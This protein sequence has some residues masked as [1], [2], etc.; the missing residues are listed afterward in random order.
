MKAP[1]PARFACRYCQYYA[2]EGRRGGSCQRLSVPVQGEWSACSL[3]SPSFSPSWDALEAAAAI[4][5]RPST[6]P[7]ATTSP[8]LHPIPVSSIV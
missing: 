5:P 4:E 1:I 8:H 2:P 7:V 3:M 6:Q